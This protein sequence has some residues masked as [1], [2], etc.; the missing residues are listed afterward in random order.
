MAKRYSDFMN[1]ITADELY[2][3]LVGHGLFAEKLPPIFDCL[4]FLAFCLAPRKQNF[5]N[6]PYQYAQFDA[7]RNIN[8]PR[9]FGIPTPMAYERLCLSLKNNWNELQKHFDDTTSIDQYK[10]SRTHIRKQPNTVCIFEM[11]YGNF[12]D[13]PLILD[14]SLGKRYVV[15]ADISKCFN[16]VYS[17]AIPWA[18]VGKEIAKANRD[19]R[20]WYNGIDQK[21]RNSKDGETH[22]IHIGPHASNILS[23][24]IL[25][26]IDR[27]LNQW[28]YLRHIDDYECYVDS[29]DDAQKFLLD[30]NN[31]LKTYGLSL[32]QGKIQILKQPA[33]SLDSWKDQMQ[34]LTSGLRSEGGTIRFKRINAFLNQ[35]IKLAKESDD[36]SALYY[37]VKTIPIDKLNL[38]AK[39]CVVKTMTSLA[40]LYPYLVHVIDEHVYSKYSTSLPIDFYLNE[41]FNRYMKEDNFDAAAHAVQLA[42]KY[43][44]ML[45][46]FSTQDIIKKNDCILLLCGLIYCRHYKLG[47]SLTELKRYAKQ[48]NSNPKDMEEYWPFVYE[49]LG[50]GLLHDD[51]KALKKANV[52]FLK[53]EYR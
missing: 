4:D 25:C 44:I 18:L 50:V 19:S 48:L 31:S 11:N 6:K 3:G 16:S 39:E 47:K 10:K 51:W 52:S 14:I 40:L 41:I 28:N 22:G 35:C 33:D 2:R 42:V 49:C 12:N 27:N 5:T 29:E 1:E 43:D 24:I 9:T 45:D 36:M 17:H 21:L 34:E 23:E 8:I 20:L 15:K 7:T 46:N 53:K 30:L 26:A 32:N 13:A 37:G 38:E